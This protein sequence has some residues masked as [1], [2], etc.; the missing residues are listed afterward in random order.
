MR[1]VR[2]LWRLGSRAVPMAG[3]GLTLLQLWRGG[4]RRVGALGWWEAAAM[5][6]L[7]AGVALAAVRRLRRRAPDAAPR[8][9]DELELGVGLVAVA[10][11]VVA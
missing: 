6:L 9:A 10:C 2:Q 7:V 5:A 8:V 4:F 11:T 3:V 1:A